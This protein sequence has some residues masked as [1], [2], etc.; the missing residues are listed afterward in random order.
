MR[1]RGRNGA[2]AAPA[3]FVAMLFLIAA[4]A[5]SPASAQVLVIA[6]Q[7]LSFGQLTPGVPMIVDPTDVGRRASYTIDARGKFALVFQLPTHLRNAQGAT[8]PVVFGNTDG[9]VEIR[10]K[11]T[12][13]DPTAGVSIHVNPADINAQVYLGGRALPLLGTAAGSYSAAIVMMVVQTG[14]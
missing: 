13:F 1:S 6:E 9:R 12:I 4:G 2:L 10:H 8:I 11:A 5:V 3:A 7:N 14:T